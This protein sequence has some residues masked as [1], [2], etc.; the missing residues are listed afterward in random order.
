MLNKSI[1]ETPNASKTALV[2]FWTAF[3]LILKPPRV[4]KKSIFPKLDVFSSLGEII[5]IILILFRKEINTN[6]APPPPPPQN[7]PLFGRTNI[8]GAF[9]EV[10]SI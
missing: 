3:L 9:S 6:L 10:S 2:L 4:H 5:A 1:Y 8:S 7:Y